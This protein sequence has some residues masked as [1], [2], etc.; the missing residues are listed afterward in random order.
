MAVKIRRADDFV[1]HFLNQLDADRRTILM[2]L[3]NPTSDGADKASNNAALALV[4]LI[5]DYFRTRWEDF[6]N[7]PPPAAADA[8]KTL[9]EIFRKEGVDEPPQS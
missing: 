3:A 8:S 9:A 5:G 6:L 4:N 7:A 1:S 2:L